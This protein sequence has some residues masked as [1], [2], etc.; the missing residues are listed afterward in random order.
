M[1]TNT[2]TLIENLF[3]LFFLGS[4]YWMLFT[5]ELD[6]QRNEGVDTLGRIL[7]FVRVVC[8]VYFF[9]YFLST[10]VWTILTETYD[11]LFGWW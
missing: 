11:I 3:S 7:S 10:E 9:H 1:L 5:L 6:M 4:I 8:Y 2:L